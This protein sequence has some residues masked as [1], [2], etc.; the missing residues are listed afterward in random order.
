MLIKNQKLM[1]SERTLRRPSTDAR[2]LDNGFKSTEYERSS[3]HS[4]LGNSSTGHSSSGHS[5]SGHSS[6]GQGS[7]VQ[8]ASAEHGPINTTSMENTAYQASDHEDELHRLR[9]DED[10][11]A[12]QLA[13]LKE[14]TKQQAIDEAQSYLQQEIEK[15]KSE[16]ESSIQACQADVESVIARLNAA[17]DSVKECELSL[18]EN[19]QSSIIKLV[20]ECVYKLTLD[21]EVFKGIVERTV[22]QVIL[23]NQGKDAL[24]IH[25]S[26]QDQTLLQSLTGLDTEKCYITVDHLLKPGDFFVESGYTTTDLSIVSQLDQVREALLSTLQEQTELHK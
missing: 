16:A 4:S 18:I 19:N 17:I 7:S 21:R 5:S 14:E 11:K 20:A 6:S 25:C 10:L 15:A 9:E 3:G 23:E 13:E 1:P 8:S 26:E 22:S 12:Q 24:K 2:L